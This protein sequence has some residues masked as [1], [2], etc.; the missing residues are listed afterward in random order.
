M[1]KY[2][3]RNEGFGQVL[4][5]LT[6]PLAQECYRAREL[7]IARSALVPGLNNLPCQKV[8]PVDGELLWYLDKGAALKL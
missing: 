8:H 4:V 6:V 2:Q 1:L 5:H 7:R 3:S